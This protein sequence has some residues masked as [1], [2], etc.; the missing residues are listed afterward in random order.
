MKF[1]P[2][3]VK[4]I[5]AADCIERAQAPAPALRRRMAAF[6][7]EGVVLFGVLMVVGFIFAVSTDQ[8][9]AL[10]YRFGLMATLFLVLALYFIWFWTHGGQTLAM[11][12]WH[13]RLVSA[14]GGP[15]SPKQALARYMTSWL[16]FVPALAAAWLLGWHQSKLLYGALFAWI[17][18]YALISALLPKHQFAHDTL[19]G[20]RL[21]DNRG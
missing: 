16:W 19:C 18:I 4:P 13:L 7:Y 3:P 15:L 14:Q 9:H 12:T 17:L 10:Q 11:K 5:T 1:S 2:P 20:T 21:I 6:L 8:R